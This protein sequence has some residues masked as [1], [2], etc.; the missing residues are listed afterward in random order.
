MTKHKTQK[1]LALLGLS[2]LASYVLYLTVY[3]YSFYDQINTKSAISSQRVLG[4]NNYLN[5]KYSNIE[6]YKRFI[7]DEQ[8]SYCEYANLQLAKA[9]HEKVMSPSKQLTLNIDKCVMFNKV[10]VESYIILAKYEL[11][12]GTKSSYSQV[13]KKIIIL[14]KYNDVVYQKI[15]QQ[16]LDNYHFLDEETK[17]L[18]NEMFAYVIKYEYFRKLLPSLMNREQ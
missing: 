8:L 6:K 7:F 3:T 1:C 9:L 10:N 15:G 5:A 13:I 16:I 17:I 14:G 12:F 11:H 4:D 18:A 2:L